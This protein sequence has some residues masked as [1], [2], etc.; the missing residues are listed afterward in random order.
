VA[1]RPAV[2]EVCR[3]VTTKH[4]ARSAVDLLARALADRDVT[5][6]RRRSPPPQ[7]DNVTPETSIC[8]TSPPP[9]TIFVIFRFYCKPEAE[10]G[11]GTGVWAGRGL[12]ARPV[13]STA[14]TTRV[15]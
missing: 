9:T 2:S 11:R 6:F 3:A 15:Q 12:S 10:A 8:S 5:S 4:I 14:P 1:R 7:R 13:H